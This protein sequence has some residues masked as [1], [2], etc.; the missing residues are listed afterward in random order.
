[1]LS[2]DIPGVNSHRPCK[3]IP[4][5]STPPIPQYVYSR[6]WSFF[7]ITALCGI[8]SF[9]YFLGF[10]NETVVLHPMNHMLLGLCILNSVYTLSWNLLLLF[11]KDFIA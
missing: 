2:G 9:C 5:L 11:K 8:G 1:M 7:L 4:K 10:T 3:P 6:N